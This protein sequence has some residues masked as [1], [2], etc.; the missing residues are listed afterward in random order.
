MKP[1]LSP[2]GAEGVNVSGSHLDRSETHQTDL[3]F[4][5]DPRPITVVLLLLLPPVVIVLL[6]LG[7]L[8]VL[9][10]LVLAINSSLLIQN[11]KPILE[12]WL[13]CDRDPSGAQRQKCEDVSYFN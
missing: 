12:N 2:G 10:V 1:P 8:L 11:R 5:D 4:Q 7:F 13:Q 3:S 9:L 6:L